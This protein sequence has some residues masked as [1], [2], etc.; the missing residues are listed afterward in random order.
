MLLA[1]PVFNFIQYL[2]FPDV[3]LTWVAIHEFGHAIG[4]D[5]SQVR[6]AIMFP[7][8]FGTT[9]PLLTY[10]DIKGVQAIY[11]GGCLYI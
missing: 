4:L 10:D 5:H 11:G 8:Y 3:D 9:V 6:V 2:V 1:H 7:Y